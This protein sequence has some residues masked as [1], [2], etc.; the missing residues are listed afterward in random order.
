MKTTSITTR[1][2]DTPK[3]GKESVTM[4]MAAGSINHLVTVL[5][6]LYSNANIAVLREVVS[7]GIDAHVRSNVN[8]PV[9]VTLPSHKNK[10]LLTV[11]DFG[12]GMSKTDIT[13]I[14]S[15]YGAST[16]RDNN[17]EMGGFGLGAKSP[18]AITDRFEVDSIHNGILIS[19][20][21]EKND[22]DVPVL[23]FTNEVETTE[24]S[25]VEVRVPYPANSEFNVSA[26]PKEMEQFFAGVPANMIS[27]NGEKL[28]ENVYN[29]NIFTNVG[30]ETA[31]GQGVSWIRS[32]VDRFQGSN[33]FFVIAGI[34]YQA[35]KKAISSL[36]KIETIVANLL[37]LNR[38]I[39]INVPVGSVR[40][41]PSRE[42]LIYAGNTITTLTEVL[43]QFSDDL[44]TYLTSYLNKATTRREAIVRAIEIHSY[45]YTEADNLRWRGEKVEKQFTPNADHVVI[46]FSTYDGTYSSTR[47]LGKKY[48][49]W[50]YSGHFARDSTL[51]LTTSLKSGTKEEKFKAT[52]LLRRY[53]RNLNKFMG[54]EDVNELTRVMI[55][56]PA[57]ATTAWYAFAQHE[58]FKTVDDLTK[59]LREYSLEL[60]R[61]ERANA[62]K[63]AAARKTIGVT[64]SWN[65][66][67]IRQVTFQKVY[68][69]DE[70]LTELVDADEIY[71]LDREDAYGFF[72]NTNVSKTGSVTTQQNT[73]SDARDF[74]SMF[75]LVVGDVPVFLITGKLELFIRQFPNAKN[76]STVVKAY[77]TEHFVPNV[78]YKW[79]DVSGNTYAERLQIE[80]I[81]TVYRTLKKNNLIET[82][83]ADWFHELKELAAIQ[84]AN[85]Q[86]STLDD[87]AQTLY[88]KLKYWSSYDESKDVHRNRALKEVSDKINTLRSRAWFMDSFST[89]TK[90]VTRLQQIVNFINIA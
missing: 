46:N 70:Q 30:G 50:S 17:T 32:C 18:L 22:L 88:S 59:E 72:P 41:T 77:A 39:Y 68:A 86:E 26:T 27:F 11:R 66:A 85:G 1:K 52:N 21:I 44:E 53:L 82:V 48:T 90:S 76:A 64:Y 84:D 2:I 34:R 7:N 35:D 79:Y 33:I 24:P 38:D 58:K 56:E 14:Y 81:L 19:F 83:S 57:D 15:Q 43:T 36:P 54:R 42:A 10:N 5:T 20:Y 4:G 31:D 29:T 78:S 45:A 23:Y 67:H 71:Y 87:E 40:L 9:Q 13:E 28:T 80:N 63:K 60:A 74:R 55:V 12:V 61:Q 16:K 47:E 49:N 75:N 6:N 8:Q 65:P 51:I 73:V 37:R 3:E 69:D 25:G 89:V 62:P